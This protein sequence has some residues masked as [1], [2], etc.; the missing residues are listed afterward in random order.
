MRVEEG[1]QTRARRASVARAPFEARS[2]SLGQLP[3]NGS[4]RCQLR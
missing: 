4:G 2:Q 3:P 1:V